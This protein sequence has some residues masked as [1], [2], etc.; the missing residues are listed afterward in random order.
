MLIPCFG[1]EQRVAS[2]IAVVGCAALVG[3]CQSK[4]TSSPA[5]SPTQGEPAP[6]QPTSEAPQEQ[7]TAVEGDRPQEMD[8]E[9]VR[10]QIAQVLQRIDAECRT[11]EGR[12][13]AGRVNFAF[14]SSGTVSKVEIVSGPK[15]PSEVVA[16]VERHFRAMRVAPFDFMGGADMHF[17]QRL[18]GRDDS[19]F[20]LKTCEQLREELEG[21]TFS[22]RKP[23]GSELMQE[24]KILYGCGP[25]PELDVCAL[26]KDGKL[27]GGGATA[28]PRNE[29][30]EACALEK[31][32]AMKFQGGAGTVLVTSEF[33]APST[34]TEKK[35]IALVIPP[36]LASAEIYFVFEGG[37]K[38]I[39]PTKGVIF[40]RTLPGTYQLRI[41]Q[42]GRAPQMVAYEITADMKNET[43]I[44][45]SVP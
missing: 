24:A 29:G 11:P 19:M 23:K 21:A 26:V 1:H 4:E 3:A 32:Q 40:I 18:L 9:A 35:T 38:L 34:D 20:P 42:P 43:R 27:T 36:E 10:D 15:Q 13:A 31:L 41:V 16:C 7:S 44:P 30:V 37:D 33:R 39:K 6:A 2:T 17:A 45:I 8:V 28:R 14:A 22:E 5:A 25:L 12:P